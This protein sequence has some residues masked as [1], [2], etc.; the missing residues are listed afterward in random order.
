MPCCDSKYFGRLHYAEDAVIQTPDGLPGFE[1]ETRFVLVQLPDQHPL[2]YIQSGTRPEL[3]FLALPILTID[4]GYQLEL[5]PEDAAV[6]G[7]SQAPAIGQ[8]VLCLALITTHPD[9]ATANLLAPLVVNLHSR[10]AA[11]CINA[12]GGYSHRHPLEAAE[13]GAAA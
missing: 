4:A 5:A 1:E 13:K 2:V 8:D 3:C 11:Q 10:I 6:I 7:T 12:A 9:G